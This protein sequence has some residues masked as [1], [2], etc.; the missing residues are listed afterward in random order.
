MHSIVN[1]KT[2]GMILLCV[3][4]AVTLAAVRYFASNHNQPN[5][6][7]FFILLVILFLPHYAFWNRIT[8]SPI[9][10][11]FV[12]IF[13]AL[14]T[15]IT[16]SLYWDSV[17]HSHAAEGVMVFLLVPGLQL[18]LYFVLWAIIRVSGGK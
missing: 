16:I 11:G 10:R 8:N 2:T 14:S 4:G 5:D 9:L 15:L 6:L 12:V 7:S 1:L 13:I 3:S 18:L 17:F